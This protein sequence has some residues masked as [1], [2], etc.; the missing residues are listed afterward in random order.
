MSESLLRLVGLK[1]R[2]GGLQALAGVSLDVE[3][4]I[5]TSIIGPNGSG[6]STV[7]NIVSGLL[8]ADQGGK[9]FK[10]LDVTNFRPHEIKAMGIARTFQHATLFPTLSILE[11]VE[12]ALYTNSETNVIEAML[13]LPR[14]R[15]EKR[16]ARERAEAVLAEIGNGQLYPRRFDYPY[17]CS[18]GEQRIVEI[19]N[20]LVSDPELILMDEPTQ[21]LNPVW[22]AQIIEIIENLK[23]RQKT[24][25]FIEHK[26]AV[27]MR[28]ADHIV[29][30][31]H[32]EK[33]AEGAPAQI[34]ENPEVIKVYLGT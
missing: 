16:A 24:I 21:G 31:D 25:L 9:Y 6:K 8:A 2:F 12:M 7:F 10:G 22:I 29:V 26:M 34:R 11:N 27:V 17:S 4:G 30:L 23:S 14:P 32:G 18:L 5:V 1:K 19:A 20:V 3:E 28:I 13:A 33:I 15:R